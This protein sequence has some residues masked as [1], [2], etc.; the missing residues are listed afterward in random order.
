MPIYYDKMREVSA[1]VKPHLPEVY[2]TLRELITDGC[3]SSCPGFI[4]LNQHWDD[5]KPKTRSLYCNFFCNM[6]RQHFWFL[7][8]LN[9]SEDCP[10]HRKINHDELLLRIDELIIALTEENQE[11]PHAK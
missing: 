7:S 4:Y 5:D 10:C 2:K 6:C 11:D 3:N 9:P 8:A 1:E